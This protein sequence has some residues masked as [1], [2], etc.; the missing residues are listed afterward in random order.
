MAKRNRRSRS[1]PAETE[2]RKGDLRSLA[3][4][5]RENPALYVAAVV[6]IVAAGAAGAFYRIY[7]SHLESVAAT[8]YARAIDIEDPA[9]RAEALRDTS[10][11]KSGLQDE[12]LYM[13][14]EAA[15]GAGNHEKAVEAFER[16]QRDFP[17]S[18]FTPAAVEGLGYVAEDKKDYAA[19]LARYREVLDKWPESFAGRR[20]PGN[21]GRCQEKNGDFEAAKQAYNDQLEIFPGS[22]EALNAELALDLLEIEHPDLFQKTPEADAQEIPPDQAAQEVDALEDVVVS[23]GAKKA[24]DT[25]QG[26]QPVGAD[27]EPEQEEPVEVTPDS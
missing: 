12:I 15:F 4:H 20:Q 8:E 23:D 3:D 24:E 2:T 27:D 19:A 21:I 18:L 9:A 10:Q 22:H 6:F 26:G 25:G 16:L 11:R 7:Q 1:E 5:A 13:S 17:N 14:G